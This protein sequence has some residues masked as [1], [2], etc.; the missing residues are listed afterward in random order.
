MWTSWYVPVFAVFLVA[1]VAH[2]RYRQ[3]AARDLA[4]RWLTAHGYHIRELRER[5][6]GD[7]GFPVHL[8]RDRDSAADFRAVVDDRKLGGTG[9]VWLRV[10][11]GWWGDDG[12]EPEVVWERMPE[13][14]DAEAPAGTPW[15]AAQLALLARVAAGERDFRP[16]AR[17]GAAPGAAFDGLVEHLLAMERRGLVTCATPLAEV[18]RPGRMYAAL[19]DVALTPEG[20]RVAARAA[21]SG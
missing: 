7:P 21:A 5:W 3:A 11:G 19:T 17:R 16:D 9:V 2:W 14:A 1:V 20:A 6:M 13:V 10:W 4:E 12:D 18:G 8:L 15:E